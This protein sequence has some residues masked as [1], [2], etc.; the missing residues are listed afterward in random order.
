MAKRVHLPAYPRVLRH[1]FRARRP[2]PDQGGVFRD[3]REAELPQ[4]QQDLDRFL[5]EAMWDPT[6]AGTAQ[7]GWL[8]QALFGSSLVAQAT[9]TLGIL[10]IA[11]DI[12]TRRK[13]FEE[14]L[15]KLAE[16]WRA[17]GP[18]RS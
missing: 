2:P 7:D 1:P 14:E 15:T 5:G 16:V 4:I 17:K 12:T 9:R 3:R 18:T 11:V 6:S 13:R 8:S 10:G